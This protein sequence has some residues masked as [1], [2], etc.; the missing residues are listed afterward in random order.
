MLHTAVHLFGQRCR[1]LGALLPDSL[2]PM[3][4]H[5]RLHALHDSAMSSAVATLPRLVREA[6]EDP[7]ELGVPRPL[8]AAGC[9]SGGGEVADARP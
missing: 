5:L 4:G 1:V 3:G 7:T 8:A 9:I 6:G 2:L